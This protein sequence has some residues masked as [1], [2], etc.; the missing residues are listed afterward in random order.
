VRELILSAGPARYLGGSIETFALPFGA[1]IVIG[2]ALYYIFK[3]PHSVPRLTYL[4]PAHQASL[5]T[6]EPGSAGVITLRRRAPQA[7]AP[8]A[9]AD[10]APADAVDPVASAADQPA[11]TGA[12]DPTAPPA[13]QQEG[14][15]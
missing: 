2:V 15:A 6:R 11:D 8:A 9:E 14:D 12:P 7:A 5:G 10:S 13:V 4:R 1:I 3:R